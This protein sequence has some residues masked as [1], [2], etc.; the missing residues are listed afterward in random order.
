MEKEK[1]KQIETEFNELIKRCTDKGGCIWIQDKRGNK[2][3]LRI[4]EDIKLS[5]FVPTVR[6]DSNGLD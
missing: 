1:A 4:E 3:S 5:A 2:Y 6:E